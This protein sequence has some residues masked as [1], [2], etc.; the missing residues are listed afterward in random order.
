MGVGPKSRPVTVTL[1]PPLCAKFGRKM[2]LVTGPSKLK[3]PTPV[4]T[5]PPTVVPLRTARPPYDVAR[6]TR[7]VPDVQ[8]VV[9]HG[10]PAARLAV[11]ESITDPKL[12]PVTV[13][14][15]LPLAARFGRACE[16]ITG[17]LKLK[18]ARPVPAIAPIVTA[19]SPNDCS[20]ALEEQPTV[21]PDV[22]DDVPHTCISS[23]AVPERS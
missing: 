16:L 11:N 9:R 21:V 6:Q 10:S 14:L 18:C 7:V 2:K 8:L 4:P 3:S 15:P 22:Q 17:L 5:T 12:R 23:A 20:I 19:D 1:R 13:T